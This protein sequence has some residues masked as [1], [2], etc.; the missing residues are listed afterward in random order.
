MDEAQ[1]IRLRQTQTVGYFLSFLVMGCG[2]AVFGPTLGL[3]AENSGVSLGTA[4]GLLSM[5]AAGYLIGSLFLARLYDKFRSHRILATVLLLTSLLLIITGVLQSFLLLSVTVI[6]MGCTLSMID[7]GGNGLVL[8][9]NRSRS[10]PAVSGLH[11]SSGFG[12][13]LAPLLVALAMAGGVSYSWG[14][15]AVA[16]L[17]IPASLLILFLPSPTFSTGREESLGNQ[18]DLKIL[19]PFALFFFFYCGAE[20]SWGDLVFSYVRKLGFDRDTAVKINSAYWG[21]MT[22]ARFLLIPLTYRFSPKTILRTGTL[23]SLVFLGILITRSEITMIWIGSIGL[24]TSMALLFPGMMSY[25]SSVFNVTGRVM[26]IFFVGVSLGAMVLPL[27]SGIL[28]DHISP[29]MLPLVVFTAMGAAAGIVL[30]VTIKYG[31]S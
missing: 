19:L 31:N 7:V 15:L 26:G 22:M 14:F 4:S 27:L 20:I 9:V 16:L 21:G 3:I 10:S 1:T 24:S 2:S 30:Y 23:L 6:L 18:T 28:L 13:F 5:R 25:T 29:V 17:F 8:F 11:I 12:K